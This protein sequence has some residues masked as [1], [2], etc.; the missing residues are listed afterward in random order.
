MTVG[1]AA[2]CQE[3]TRPRVVFAADRMITTGQNPR[4]EYEHT[5]SKIQAVHDNGVVSCMGVASGTVSYIE[6][7]FHRLEE[8]LDNGD[9]IAVRDIAEKAN[10]AYTELGKDTVQ[11]KV[12]DQ[13][14]IELESLSNNQNQFDTDI[15]SG[16]LSDISE[17]QQDFASQLEVVLGGIDGSGGPQIFSIQAF[18]MN[19][20]NNIGYHTIGSG[21]QPARSVF[22]RNQ[23]DT[24]SNVKK[25]LLTTI[26]SKYR[27]EE[28]RGVGNELDVAVAKQ[29][30]EGE[31][32]CEVLDETRKG[33]W[34]DLY[35]DIVTAEQDA[36][37]DV[38]R[39]AGLE[40][41]HGGQQ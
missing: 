17:A 2:I 35:D 23:Y 18:D 28:A 37:E 10:D 8:K 15:L 25:G 36:R 11:N 9:P 20:Q 26:E 27:S 13:F 1:I 24:T 22:I 41:T 21:T 6:E 38:I 32:C 3:D 30:I 12:L 5:K 34:V 39:D 14:G 31:T 19:P 16:L 40:Y 33:E 4:I 29:P 7:F